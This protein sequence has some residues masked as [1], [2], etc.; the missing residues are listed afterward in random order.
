MFKSL[1]SKIT[2]MFLCIV[3]L[4]AVVG[5]TSVFNIYSI[6]KSVDG[7]MVDNYTSIKASGHMFEAL[8]EQNFSIITYIYENDESSI[9]SFHQN[10][11]V[12]YK[13]FNIESQHLTPESEKEYNARLKTSYLKYNSLFSTLQGI[14]STKG[15]DAAAAFFTKEIIPVFN[16]M[17]EQLMGISDVNEKAMFASKNQTTQSSRRS[18][19]VVLFLTSTAVLGGFIISKYYT[20]KALKPVHLL[21]ETVKSIKEGNLNAEAPILSHD[22]I[23]ILAGEFNNMTKRLQEFEQSAMGKLLHEK[24]K[25]LAIVKSISNP[26][27][28]LD[29]N[30]KILLLNDACEDVFEISEERA[31]NRHVLEVIRN[32]EIYEYI[33]GVLDENTVEP[34][35]KI[36]EYKS[37][38][39]D[40]YFN[41]LVTGVKDRDA[42]S[43]GAVVLFQ[44]ITQL[45]QLEK[46]KTDFISTVSHEFKTPLT[47]IMIG[48][49]LLNDKGLGVMNQKQLEV[50][51]TISEDVDR[52][53]LLVN[54]LLKISR[55]ES[56]KSLF[57]FEYF[58][59]KDIVMESIKTFHDQVQNKKI[60]LDYE[61]EEDLPEVYVDSE[62]ITWVINN[63]ISNAI[64]FTQDNGNI[65]VY[66]Y[67]KNEKIYISVKDT[68]IGIPP[69]YQEKI[70]DK[71]V[72]IKNDAFNDS[73]T[74]LGLSIAKEVIEAHDGEI[75]CESKPDMGSTFIFTLPI[76]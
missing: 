35:Q 57:N 42:K 41:V 33:S 60:N 61:I 37:K 26:L 64:K 30:Y 34:H 52:L 5:I 28:V 55:I 59:I 22:E 24:N 39:K 6:T 4:I 51:N 29:H 17:K 19:Q 9:D 58:S 31:V 76:K 15:N 14:K 66:A 27:L 50:V 38:S 71:F 12:F 75:W 1:K 46:I 21:T 73:G 16:D 45:K 47:S 49:S 56:D 36:M 8:E 32:N 18:L 48:M 53:S 70:F 67:N 2:F 72:Q 43:Y 44:N 13:W 25:S 69:E 63:L 10:G 62:K 65:S 20:D 54:N 68:G 11:D 3:I 40:Y 74:G 7:L 23:G